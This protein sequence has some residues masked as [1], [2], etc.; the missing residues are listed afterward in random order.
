MYSDDISRSRKRNPIVKVSLEQDENR[1]LSI[2]V[3]KSKSWVEFLE[4]CSL[5]FEFDI[6]NIANIYEIAD[7]NDRPLNFGDNMK[8]VKHGTAFQ[9]VLGEPVESSSEEEV[10]VES[11]SA[12]LEEVYRQP[13]DLFQRLS[14]LKKKHQKLRREAYKLAKQKVWQLSE[15]ESTES[16]HTYLSDDFRI[17]I[18]KNLL[19]VAPEEFRLNQIR[20]QQTCIILCHG[21]RFAG[22]IFKGAQLLKSKKLQR[23]VVRKKQGKRQ[24]SHMSKG[25]CCGSAGG[26]L[27]TFHEKKLHAD[28]TELLSSWSESLDECETILIHAPGNINQATIFGAESPLDRDDERIVKLQIQTNVVN[29]SEVKRIHFSISTANLLKFQS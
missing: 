16:V 13:F 20:D 29:S 11:D 28:I 7:E 25:G 23:Y 8:K 3:P 14:H 27:R 19:R 12:E 4:K 24:L 17:Q 10:E 21:G 15:D 2:A 9:I 6:R 5:R 22:G 26:W 18:S 1:V